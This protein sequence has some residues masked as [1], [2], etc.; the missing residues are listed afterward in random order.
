MKLFQ[1]SLFILLSALLLSCNPN[2]FDIDTSNISVAPVSFNRLEQDLFTMDTSKIMEETQLLQQKY[3]RFY[4]TFI[5]G[6]VNNGGMKDSA[7]PYRIK[8][9]IYD[10]DMR[11]AY[12]NCQQTYPDLNQLNDGFTTIFK[13]FKYFFPDRKLPKT[14]TM[15]SGFNHATVFVDST[16]AIG[17]EMYLGGDNKFYQ[18]L[19]L[20]SYKVVFMNKENITTDA[21]RTWMFSEFPYIMNKND[22]LSE[23][24]NMGK[25]MYLNDAL[26][27]NVHDTT[28]IQY[29]E[30]QLRYCTDNEF[31][32]WTFFIAQKL[33]YTTDY[34]EIVK[35]TG[36]APFTAA[37]SKES[38]PRIGHWIGWQI[39]RQY[40]DTNPDVTLQQLMDETDAQIILAKSKYKP[41]K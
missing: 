22:F 3:G 1:Q 5:T 10:R 28:K 24:I 19:A 37:F 8:R 41:K 33:L 32:V 7:Y 9:F 6:I 31:N 17:L 2:R 29:T 11:D 27:P 39:V 15:M 12:N 16:L 40:M 34:A 38:A 35:F 4:A 23:I 25:I 14:T 18:M 36:E 20:P 26:L 21:V 13:R 30:K